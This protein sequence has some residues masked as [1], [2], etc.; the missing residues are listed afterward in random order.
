MAKFLRDLLDAEEPLFSEA[1]HQLELASGKQAAD[2]KLIGDITAMAH[3][4][5]RQMGLNPATSTGEEVYH[6]LEARV[7]Q[8]IKRLTKIIGADVEKSEDVRYLVPFMVAAANKVTFNRK[9]F[10]IKHESAKSL[11]R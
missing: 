9:V 5:L 2:T 7:E 8:D 11:L 6:G 4:N 10:V 3:E 1:L